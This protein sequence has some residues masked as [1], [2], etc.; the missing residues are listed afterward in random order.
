MAQMD[1]LTKAREIEK[2]I[3]NK[4]LQKFNERQDVPLMFL[5]K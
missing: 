1:N 5:P 2:R 3:L 4:K